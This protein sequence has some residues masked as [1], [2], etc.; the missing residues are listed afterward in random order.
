[1]ENITPESVAE[2]VLRW[3]QEAQAEKAPAPAI[4]ASGRQ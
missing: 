3:R 2:I 4:S 1:M